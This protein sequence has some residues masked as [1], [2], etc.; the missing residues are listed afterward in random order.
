[1][2]LIVVNAALGFTAILILLRT[3]RFKEAVDADRAAA[4]R[5]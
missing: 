3:L 4:E 5:A 1:V 2:T